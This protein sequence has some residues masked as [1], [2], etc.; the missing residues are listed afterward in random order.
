VSKIRRETVTDQVIAEVRQSILL[1][2]LPAGTP[3]T[4]DG[5]SAQFGVSRTTTRQ[6]L[7]T[8]M[9]EGLLTRHPTTRILQVTTLTP[10]DVKDIYRARRF[11]ELGGIDAAD[12]AQPHQLDG[13]R[14]AIAELRRAV[15]NDDLE[16]FVQ[17]DFN[18]HAAIVGFLGS[19]HL[20]EAYGLLISKLRVAISRI[21]LDK[22]DNT[23]SLHI[24]EL[25]VDQVL[26]GDIPGARA[27]LEQRLDESERVVLAQTNHTPAA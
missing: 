5:M 25:F 7:N 8:L 3:L 24:H 9:L 19:R 16:G 13:L 18:C 15:E 6:A 27:S 10:E 4:E 23:A 20:S 1:S 14:T 2:Q 12:A 11:L 22:R 17:A 21:T 26:H